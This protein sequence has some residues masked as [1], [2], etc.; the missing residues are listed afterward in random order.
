[1]ILLY[2]LLAA[3][4]ISLWVLRNYTLFNSISFFFLLCKTYSLSSTLF[5]PTP[6]LCYRL[7]SLIKPFFLLYS[8]RI[9][10][11][12]ILISYFRNTR[13]PKIL[14][15]FS[16]FVKLILLSEKFQITMSYVWGLGNLD[17]YINVLGMVVYIGRMPPQKKKGEYVSL[18][19][20]ILP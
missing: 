5:P 17:L 15:C 11:L 9:P 1:M 7:F 18:R 2:F 12:F 6:L 3:V 13:R 10:F 19:E 8:V 20:I 16:C 14:L 4:C